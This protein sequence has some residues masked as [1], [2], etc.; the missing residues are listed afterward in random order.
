YFEKVRVIVQNDIPKENITIHCWSSENDLGT[1]PLSYGANFPWHF[2][3]NFWRTT[4]FYCDFTTKHGSGN[5]GVYSKTRAEICHNYCF[6]RITNDGPC[7]LVKNVEE[8]AYCQ[9]WK[10]PAPN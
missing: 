6:W 3:V 2:R 7:L 5:Y 10:H 9:D 1:H 8:D 4:K